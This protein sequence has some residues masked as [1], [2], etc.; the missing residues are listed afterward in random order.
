MNRENNAHTK[1]E[2]S[3]IVCNVFHKP[4]YICEFVVQRD[5]WTRLDEGLKAAMLCFF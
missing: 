4:V 1:I 5:V 2:G 3:I